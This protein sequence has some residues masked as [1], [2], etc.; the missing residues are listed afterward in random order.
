M[1]RSL[2]SGSLSFG[3]LNIPVS[4]MSPKG[5]E[6]ISFDLLDKRD[7]GR[8]G[9]KKYNKTTGKEVKSDQIVKA[10]EYEPDQYVI[11]TDDDLKKAN[12]RATETID[13]EDFIYL[14]EVD[15]LLFEKP[16]YLVPGKRGDKGYVLLRKVMERTLKAAIGKIVM[17]KKQRLVAIVP[18]GDY[19]VMEVLRF[20]HEIIL[21]EESNLLSDKIN[22]VKIAPRELEMAE[23]L[24][25]GMTSRWQPEKYRDTYREDMLKMIEIKARK[26]AIEISE[27][28]LEERLAPNTQVIDLMP[29]LKKSLQAKAKKRKRTAS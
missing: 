7:F 9:Y 6:S 11:I 17:H 25:D 20:A 23:E 19:L 29:L 27:P 21:P 15:P 13:I 3:L 18:R 4:V 8:I 1:A 22:E 12:P 5:E 2:W 10:F 14:K 26:G 28:E 24:V 16:Y